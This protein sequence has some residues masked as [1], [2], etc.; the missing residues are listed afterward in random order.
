MVRQFWP[1]L[2]FWPTYFP[3]LIWRVYG[4]VRACLLVLDR[5]PSPTCKPSCSVNESY[6]LKEHPAYQSVPTSYKLGASRGNPTA[7]TKYVVTGGE[8]T[9]LSPNMYCLRVNPWRQSVGLGFENRWQY[10][11][12]GLRSPSLNCVTASQGICC[13]HVP[14]YDEFGMQRDYCPF[15]RSVCHY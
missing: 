14:K 5:Y 10:W 4:F 3:V 2:E 13:H 15:E 9:P 1:T 8:E 6:L 11:V 12:S 7:A